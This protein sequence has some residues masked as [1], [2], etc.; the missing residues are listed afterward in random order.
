MSV[1]TA[2]GIIEVTHAGDLPGCF[3]LMDGAFLNPDCKYSLCPVVKRCEDLGVG[4][5][6]SEG[7]TSASFHKGGKTLVDLDVSSG[8]PT[9]SVGSRPGSLTLPAKS[10]LMALAYIVT[11]TVAS[12]DCQSPTSLVSAK[13]PSWMFQHDLDGHKPVRPD[14]PY[15]KQA[16][17]TE[18]RA[19]RVPHS[20][21]TE[22]SGYHL[23]GYFCGPHP[24][25]VD[26]QTYA[27][28]GVESTTNWGFVW[29]QSSRPATDTLV[30]QLVG[31][32][33]WFCSAVSSL[34]AP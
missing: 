4:F 9:F 11:G 18:T 32:G 27:F 26:G 29:L 20:H 14:C 8:L 5:T 1:S 24:L 31:C 2:S 16:S 13:H 17:L 12:A 21:I 6:V 3:D 15:R 23:A 30:S 7:A 25:S 19:F 34:L 10:A 22:K 33:S 28:I